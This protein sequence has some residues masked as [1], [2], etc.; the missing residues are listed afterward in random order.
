MI[1]KLFITLFLFLISQL[2]IAQ[3]ITGKVIG[4]KSGESIPYANIQI[5]AGENLLT[6]AEGYFTVPEKYSGDD[7]IIT[8]SYLG[9]VGVRMTLGELRSKQLTI[10][11]EEGV[12]ALDT[13]A[14][15]KANRNLDSI[16]AEVKRN[17]SRNYKQFTQPARKTLFYRETNVFKPV[18][19]DVEITKSTGFKKDGLKSV[20]TQLNA[21]TSNIVSHPPQ[22]FTDMLANY[23]TATKTVDNKVVVVPKFDVVKATKLKDEKRS[24]SVEEMQKNAMDILLQHLDT[25]K[26]YR[27]KSGLFGSRDTVSLRKDFKKKSTKAKKSTLTLAKTEV[28]TFMS[29]NSFLHS[30]KL[31]FVNHPELY[32]YVYDGAVFSNTND[33]IYVLKF[34]PKKSK[35]KYTGTLFISETDYAIVRA[36]YTLEEGKTLGGLNLKFLLGIKASENVSKGTMIFKQRPGEGEGYYMQYASMESGQYIYINRPLKF[37]ELA[38]KEKDVVAFDLKLEANMLDKQ[39]FL[40]LSQSE[41]TEAEYDKAKE[42][43]FDYIRLKSYDPKIWKDYSAIEPLEEMKQFKVVE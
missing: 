39:E 25:T 36:D 42:E 2:G 43:E 22:Q 41:I 12:F 18:K 1:Q 11:L 37:I 24:A 17:L 15:S 8:V 10:T 23:Y 5:N 20:N 30:T 3:A 14:V 29:Q 35:A 31:D 32:E 27:I 16:M 28:M 4:S 33:F 19:L 9:Y 40:N 38:D 26:Y 13:V 21:F 6:N 7:A 34:K